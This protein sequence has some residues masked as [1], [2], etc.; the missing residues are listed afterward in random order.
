MAREHAPNIIFMDEFDSI[1]SSRGESSNGDGDLEVQRTMLELLDQF[2]GFEA[3][4][5]I[6]VIMAMNRIG[7]YLIAVSNKYFELFSHRYPRLR[8]PSPPYQQQNRVPPTRPGG[9]PIHSTPPAFAEKMGQCSGSEVRGIC[10]EAG[11]YALPGRRRYITQEDF[12]FAVAK[13]VK[14]NHEANTSVN[15]LFS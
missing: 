4:K 8:T 15:K 1:G 3:T 6:K 5:N 10:T 14:K 11:M 13:D 2:D 7:A 9:P 12:E